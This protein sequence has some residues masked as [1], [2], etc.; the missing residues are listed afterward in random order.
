DDFKALAGPWQRVLEL[1]R[2]VAQAKAAALGVAP[3]DALLD[4]YEPGGRAAA[5]EPLLDALAA[6]LPPL[7]DRILERQ[8]GLEAPRPLDGPFALAAQ[9]ELGLTFM[10][11][12]GFDFEHGRLDI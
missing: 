10:R 9:R 11:A 6:R 7:I 8:R 12:L 3:Y 1:T 2:E 5:I 4:E